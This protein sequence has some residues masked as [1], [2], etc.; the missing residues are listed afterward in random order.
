MKRTIL[1][2]IPVFVFS[3]S[4][5]A[6]FSLPKLPYAYDALEPYI[7]SETM[8]IHYNHHHATYV[9][10]LNKALESYPAL[11]QKSV[12]DLIKDINGLPR[13]IQ[14]A[15]R[16]NGGGHY[17]H[18]LFWSV[19]APAGTTKMSNKLKKAIEKDF[20]SVAAFK[21]EFEKAATGRFGSGWAWLVKDGNGKLYIT[22]TANQDN[23]LM[24]VADVKGS[25]ILG[26]DVW[27]HA[28]Y[29]KYQSKRADYIKAFWEVVNWNEVEKLFEK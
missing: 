2:L 29:L 16:N 7:D 6:Q 25:P 19:L 4:A 9:N 13:D 11:Q 24:S 21:S 28:Y 18:T 3:L 27:E 5:L 17:N 15:I 26:L 23:P 12:E 22:S 10:N 8:Y 1:L 14:T 20:G